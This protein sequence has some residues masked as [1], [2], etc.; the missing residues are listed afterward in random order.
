VSTAARP[1]VQPDRS[2]PTTKGA[3]RVIGNHTVFGVE[4]GYVVDLD[5]PTSSFDALAASGNI[6]PNPVEA[7]A[8]TQTEQAEQPVPVVI[9]VSDG[10][11]VQGVDL[12]NT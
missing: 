12:H 6:D 9:H 10:D 1:A 2:V 11:A 5:L 8:P 3:Y 4:P 7:P